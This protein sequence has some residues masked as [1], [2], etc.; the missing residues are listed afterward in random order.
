MQ[1][2]KEIFTFTKNM[3]GFRH[4]HHSLKRNHFFLDKDLS[5]D[6]IPDITWHGIE[7]YKP[8]WDSD[9]RSVA[10]MISG[11]DFVDK[12]TPKDN[13]IYV[14]LNSYWEPLWFELPKLPNKKWYRVL[15]T[16]RDKGDPEFKEMELKSSKYLVMDRSSVILISK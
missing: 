12:D 16:Y 6:G 1:E 15:D 5:G 14:A 4:K 7:A 8:D 10:F 3:I 9:S 11:E 13:D 2:F